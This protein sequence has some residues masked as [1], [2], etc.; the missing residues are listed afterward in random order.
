MR[1]AQTETLGDGTRPTGE[2]SKAT[3]TLPGIGHRC[4]VW[5][6][7]HFISGFW[8]RKESMLIDAHQ[9]RFADNI[10]LLSARPAG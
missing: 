5:F 2:R 3:L 10:L 6:G 4:S 8:W 7:S 1:L 9:N